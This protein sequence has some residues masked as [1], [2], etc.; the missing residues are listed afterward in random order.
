MKGADEDMRICIIK[1][2]LYEGSVAARDL[3]LADLCDLPIGPDEPIRVTTKDDSFVM[4]LNGDVVFDFDKFD[5]KPAAV[6]LL[7]RAANNIKA[8]WRSGT[9]VR[10]NGYTD[11]SE[12]TTTTTG[13]PSGAPK[14]SQTRCPRTAWRDQPSSRAASARPVRWRRTP[15]RAG[16]P[17]TVASKSS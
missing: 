12:A 15:A 2:V 5:I 14:P 3:K 4:I 16:A 8:I 9:T 10:I 11:K 6:P 7:D 1:K 17:G 13:C